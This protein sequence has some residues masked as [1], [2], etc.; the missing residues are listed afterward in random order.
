LLSVASLAGCITTSQRIA[1]PPKL[2]NAPAVSKRPLH[3]GVYYSN[4]FVMQEHRRAL[5]SHSVIA[6]IG[7]ISA[8]MFDGLVAR[9]FERSSRLAALTADEMRQQRVDV[10]IAVA[11]EHFDFRIGFDED[12]DR[13]SVAYR[14]TLH[15]PSGVPVASWI[16]VGN[17]P[18]VGGMMAGIDGMVEGD[19]TDAAY[20]FL[21]GFSRMADPALAAMARHPAGAAPLADAGQVTL[22]AKR[23]DLSAFKP[24][25]VQLLAKAGV[26]AIEVTARSDA[27]KPLTMRASDMRLL[28]GSDFSA[29]PASPSSVLTRMESA[30]PPG[31]RAVMIG[32]LFSVLADSLEARERQEAQELR[33]REGGRGAF[34]DRVVAR[35]RPATGLVL[36][37]ASANSEYLRAAR[38]S[39]WIVDPQDATG[40]R[41]VIPVTGLE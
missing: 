3:A 10:G 31:A 36:F 4:G 29:E 7:P 22:S 15:S 37:S 12:S 21:A 26:Q 38:L 27:P 6:Q 13:Y 25:V 35:D 32:P 33:F 20:K 24:E 9:L 40:A 41:L 5:G 30:S 28:L 34:E 18:P 17:G 23:S 2:E 8:R 16:V 11:L 14:I 1:T 19:L 39:V